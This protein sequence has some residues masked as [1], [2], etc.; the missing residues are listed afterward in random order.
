[1]IGKASWEQPDPRLKQA[2][3][4]HKSGKADQAAEI[5]R[6]IL[7]KA[8]RRHDLLHLLGMAEYKLGRT[9]QAVALIEAAINEDATVPVYRL[10][11]ARI[12]HN[13][14]RYR[15]AVDLLLRYIDQV[16]HD[17]TA[18]HLLGRSLRLC[19]EFEAALAPARQAHLADPGNSQYLFDYA[20]SL[21]RCRLTAQAVQAYRQLMSLAPG[22]VEGTRNLAFALRGLNRAE[23]ALSVIDGLSEAA[24]GD[25]AIQCDRGE[26]FEEMGDFGKAEECYRQALALRSGY[27]T[28]LAQLLKLRDFEPD[29]VLIEQASA[30]LRDDGVARPLRI[31][32]HFS[33][34]RLHDRLGDVDAAFAQYRA[35]NELAG[36]N[37]P[38]DP[39]LVED[40]I[41]AMIAAFNRATIDRLA[42]LAPEGDQ[43]IFIVGM[44][45]S[46]T[47][48]TEQILSSHPAI[49][50]GGELGFFLTCAYDLSHK[51]GN[52]RQPF[53]YLDGIDRAELA[54]IA[55]AYSAELHQ[56]GGDAQHIT[57]KMPLNFLNLGLIAVCFPQSRIIHCRRSPLDNC[58]SCFIENMHQDQN[59]S[60]SLTALGHYYRQYDRLMRHWAQVLPNAILDMRYEELVGDFETQAKRLVGFTGLDWDEGCLAF[61][62]TRRAVSTPSKWQVRQ[63]IYATSVARW[64]R[65]ARHLEPLRQSLGELVDA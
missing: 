63:P 19:G 61:H 52:L 60:T 57:D 32:L 30:H 8:P 46:G 35:A 40:H 48:L 47:T 13:T 24:L 3:A 4:L 64:H 9:A 31:Q 6:S 62:T 22:H 53:A 39:G 59:Y 2:M 43:P 56:A 42:A 49:A 10:N 27:P 5:Y 7:A 65:Y 38:Y 36:Q 23:E 28:A 41:D 18:H 58:L 15:E 12:C 26:T 55:S 25:P 44:P 1:M 16:P 33:L 45:R 14:D 51:S 20:E 11:L 37:H 50:G 54:R 17:S 34:G 29:A 21:A